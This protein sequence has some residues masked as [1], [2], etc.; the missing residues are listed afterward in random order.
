MSLSSESGRSTIG[1]RAPEPDPA[2]ADGGQSDALAVLADDATVVH[3]YP[4]PG[5]LAPNAPGAVIPVVQ[6]AAAAAGG[7]VA[8]AA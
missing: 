3:A 5:S 2:S 7:F 4:L 1:A 8:G 6:A